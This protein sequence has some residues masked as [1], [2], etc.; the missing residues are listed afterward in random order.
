MTDYTPN[1]TKDDIDR[2]IGRDYPDQRKEDVW[3]ILEGYGSG[4]SFR[5]FAAALKEGKGNLE[6]LKQMVD[7]AITDYRDLLAAA[8][9]PAQMKEGLFS[10]HSPK[11][12]KEDEKQYYD[13]FNK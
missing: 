1:V 7:L 9:Y 5:V 6:R 4:E 2:I 12:M 3:S 8:E 10:S 11:T 13:W